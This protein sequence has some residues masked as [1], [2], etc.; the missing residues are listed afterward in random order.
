LQVEE[1][2]PSGPHSW[3]D[4]TTSPTSHSTNRMNPPIMTM[5]GSSRRWKISQRRTR[6]KATLR[7]ATVM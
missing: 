2:E 6:M 4:T 5:E 7:E 1:T 3:M